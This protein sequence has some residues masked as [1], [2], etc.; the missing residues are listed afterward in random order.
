MLCPIPAAGHALGAQ[1]AVPICQ[2]PTTTNATKCTQTQRRGA[3][4][5]A[6]YLQQDTHWG[7]S[8]LCPFA[9]IQ[10]LAI[11]QNALRH[12]VGAQHA[13]PDTCSRTRTGGTARCALC[14]YSTTG[15]TTE[16]SQ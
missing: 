5:C 14:Q 12:S 2:Y 15:N 16:C 4:C 1:P 6:R 8:P 11:Q 10:L 3:A 9:S 13:V 7:H